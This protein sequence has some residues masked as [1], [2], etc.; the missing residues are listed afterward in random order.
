M[1]DEANKTVPTDASNAPSLDEEI[2]RLSKLSR[3]EYQLQRNEVAE[4]FGIRVTALDAEVIAR[5]PKAENNSGQGQ[6]IKWPKRE[7]WDEPVDG[8]VLIDD[9]IKFIG[10]RNGT[11]GSCRFRNQNCGSLA[12]SFV[13]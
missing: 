4:R 7:P 9:I 10:W 6:E 11:A 3:V 5:Q 1:L 2:L 12:A 8:A 13:R